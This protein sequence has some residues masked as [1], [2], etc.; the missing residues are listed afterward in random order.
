MTT[1][2]RLSGPFPARSMTF[3]FGPIDGGYPCFAKPGSCVITNYVRPAVVTTYWQG[4]KGTLYE[5]QVDGR[6]VLVEVQDGPSSTEAAA[7][8]V[9]GE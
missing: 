4:D 2:P 7:T 8:I 1:A 6:S 9:I 3:E 5:L